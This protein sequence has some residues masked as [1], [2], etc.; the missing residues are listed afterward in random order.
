MAPGA[1]RFAPRGPWRF[2]NGVRTTAF[3][4]LSLLSMLT[5]CATE[6]A[7][8][9]LGDVERL[10]PTL[11]ALVDPD[12]R[13]EVLA[14]GF[15]WSEG[16]L[17]IPEDGG[18]VI[19]SDIPPNRVM[20]WRSGEGVSVYLEQSGYL[21]PIPRPGHVRP[22][23]PGSNGLLLDP[24]GRLVLCQHGERQVG[25]MIA[26]LSAP[27]PR[28]EAVADAFDGKRLN[29]PN[30][31]VFHRNGDLYFTDPPYGMARK[32]QDPEKALPF[33][34][35]YRRSR[36]GAVTL[37]T[38][39]MS[40]P[41]GLAFSPDYRTL[42]VANSDPKRAVWMAFPLQA[43][44]TLS[45]GR[46]LFDATPLAGQLKGLPDGLKVDR[47]GNLFATGPGGV[48]VLTP[49][50]EHLGTLHTGEA[51]SNCAFGEDGRSLFVTADRYLLRVRLK[52]IGFG[53]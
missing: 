30:D 13:F 53:F 39:Q 8:R 19:F 15:D 36:D 21:G 22:D 2:N 28:Y 42:Y 14:D 7:L 18:Y 46:V 20:K 51:T 50:G 45:E 35:V 40:R 1:L 43:D 16:P 44:G 4:S 27:A 47:L 6:D 29:S 10:S 48:L 38:D 9:P 12:A 3:S 37:L 41:N 49:S 23:E 32:M 33:Q 11:D 31:A 26:P 24:Q 5:A 34:G 25:R 17:W 52:T